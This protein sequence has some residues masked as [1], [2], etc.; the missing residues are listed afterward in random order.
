MKQSIRVLFLGFTL[1]AAGVGVNAEQQAVEEEKAQ[2]TES[3]I[4][5]RV[6]SFYE[7]LLKNDRVAALDLVASDSKNQFL[8]SQFAAGLIDYRVV[9][10]E[11]EQSGERAKVHVVRVMRIAKMGQPLDVQIIDTWQQSN[12]QWC[13]VLPPPGEVDT[14]FGKIKLGTNTDK[15]STIDADAMRQRVEEHYKNVDPDQYLRA[16]QKIARNSAEGVKPGAKPSQA[17][18]PDSKTD[19]KQTKPGSATPAPPPV[20]NPKPQS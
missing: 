9:G 11:L 17:V 10:V 3:Q 20:D 1:L 15:K 5:D 19:N 13:F 18:A 16:L 14:P 4:K 8:N 12:G 2:P 6:K 7:A